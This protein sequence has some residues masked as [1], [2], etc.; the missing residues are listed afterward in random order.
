MTTARIGLIAGLFIAASA[1]AGCSSTSVQERGKIQGG[2]FLCASP[3]GQVSLLVFPDGVY[4]LRWQ[5]AGG[6]RA[7]G[8][9][10]Q[11][12]AELKPTSGPLVGSVGRSSGGGLDFVSTSASTAPIGR[13]ETAS[14]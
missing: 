5:A 4:E 2:A 10:E 8:W 9:L 7:T 11:S 1:L 6:K 12:G 13:C 3:E 14:S